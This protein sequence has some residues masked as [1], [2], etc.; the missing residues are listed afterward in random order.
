MSG[1]VAAVEFE[2]AMEAS[3]IAVLAGFLAFG[4]AGSAPVV[5]LGF[6]VEV[7]AAVADDFAAFVAV[8]VDE[9][10]FAEQ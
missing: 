10:V 3:D 6:E 2:A 8:G 1:G 7:S 9:V 5:P 4:F